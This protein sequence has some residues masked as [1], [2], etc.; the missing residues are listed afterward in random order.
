MPD[1]EGLKQA[2]LVL[3]RDEVKDLWQQE[4][5]EFL[6]Q[7]A[8]DMAR[9]KILAA[10]G[11]NPEEHRR[12]L[13]FLAATLAG[14]VTKRKLKLNKVGREV[15]VRVLVAVVKTVALPGLGVIL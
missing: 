2:I 6:E 9:E 4:D 11:P 15:F 3:L 5:Q 14:E 7:L 1:M 13:E 10:T 12:N 8:T